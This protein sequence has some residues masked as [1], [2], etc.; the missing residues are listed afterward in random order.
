MNRQED[1][2]ISIIITTLA[3]QTCPHECNVYIALKSIVEGMDR[4][5]EKRNDGFWV[6]NPVLPNENFAEKWN[7]HPDKRQAFATWLARAK[8][9]FVDNPLTAKGLDELAK[10]F[11]VNLGDAPVTR[12]FS[13]LGE[14][15]RIFRESG[16]LHLT[17]LTSGLAIGATA[18]GTVVRPH[19]FYGI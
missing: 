8:A 10:L 12:A 17:G 15:V 16:S 18:S 5:I 2:P 19:T 6:P 9:D 14:S 13:S 7:R 3:A 1:A 11:K 4:F